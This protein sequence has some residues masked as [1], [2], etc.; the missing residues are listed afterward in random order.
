MRPVMT[1]LVLPRTFLG[2]R[3][4][5]TGAART[6]A[7]HCGGTSGLE[8]RSP[9]S[10]G[11]V[12]RPSQPALANRCSQGDAVRRVW[13]DGDGAGNQLS[14]SCRGARQVEEEMRIPM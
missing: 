5:R 10:A 6:V 2:G 4:M 1:S 9:I 11:G 12:V 13:H 8:E 3:T 7:G 14:I